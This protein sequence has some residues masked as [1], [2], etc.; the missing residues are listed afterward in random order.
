M[1]GFLAYALAGAASGAGEGMIAEARAKREAAMEELRN[2]RLMEREDRDRSFRSSEREASQGFTAG[3]NERTRAFQRE[4][5]GTLLDGPED[6]LFREQGGVANP[7]TDA[8]GNPISGLR[9]RKTDGG[10]T[11]TA[12][13]QAVALRDATK[14]VRNAYDGEEIIDAADG[15]RM[16]GVDAKQVRAFE[17]KQL[18]ALARRNGEDP[19]EVV[20]RFSSGGAS[21]PAA[22][23]TA[24]APAAPRGDPNSPGARAG[25]SIGA[26]IQGGTQY[27]RDNPAE[28][29]TK[30]DYD[31]LPSGAHYVVPETG[32]LKVKR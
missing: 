7:V 10:A 23:A 19:D 1:A 14:N 12:S 28:P 3:E 22:T 9:R 13:Q 17:Q 11:L 4:T 6:T 2:S 8:E 15:L 18:R 20:R 21:Q 26:A 16:A 31:A 5:G 25:A 27:S 32:E 30:Q 24:A 29:M